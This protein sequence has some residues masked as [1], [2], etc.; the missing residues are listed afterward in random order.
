MRLLNWLLRG[1]IFFT[2]FAFTLNNQQEVA[3]HWFF[4]FEWRTRMV[5]VVLAAF[6]AGCGVGMLTMLPGWL[7]QRQVRPTPSPAAPVNTMPAAL[8]T[9]VIAESRLREGL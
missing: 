3:V 1:F 7:R 2:L 8:P 9:D 5:F 4:G 6:T